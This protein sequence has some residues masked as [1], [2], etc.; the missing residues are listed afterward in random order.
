MWDNIINSIIENSKEFDTKTPDEKLIKLFEEIGELSQAYLIK[1]G[2]AGTFHR[3]ESKYS[4]KEEIA[5]SF[6]CLISLMQMLNIHSDELQT[7]ILK[8]IEKWVSKL[9]AELAY[10][11]L[12]H[13]CDGSC[14]QHKLIKR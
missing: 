3:D 8:K 2:S 6:I 10:K 11:S 12:P 7:E 9:K 14:E 4:V 5:D 13:V 1:K